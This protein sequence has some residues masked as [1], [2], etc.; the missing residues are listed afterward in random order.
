MSTAAAA[1]QDATPAFRRR[2][3]DGLADSITER[4]Y[5]ASTVA[6]VVRHAK[7]SKRTFYDE[8]ASKEEA[9]V[10]LLRANNEDLVARITAA[11]APDSTPPDQ[12][13]AAVGA[14]V[15]HIESRP[16]ITL[17]WIREAP[18]LGDLA[19]PLNRLAMQQLTDMLVAISTSPGFA[20]A[21]LAPISRPLALILL[22][23]LRELTALLVEEGEDVRG[24]VA[25]AVTAARAILGLPAD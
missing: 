12:I 1:M 15:A 4:G 21:G 22:G 11:V 10:E 25:P 7:T 3:L 17:S 20:R 18:A 2:L 8:F 13:D 14:Y 6:D 19:R 16:A 5:R 23:G 9:F 24:I